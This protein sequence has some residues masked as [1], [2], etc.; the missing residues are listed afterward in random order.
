MTAMD[1]QT[2]D[3]ARAAALAGNGGQVSR[4][5]I[6]YTV[7]AENGE[8][9]LRQY[10]TRRISLPLDDFIRTEWTVV[11]TGEAAP[12]LTVAQYFAALPSGTH[13]RRAGSNDTYV[14]SGRTAGATG[15]PRRPVLVNMR[16]GSDTTL[17][18]TDRDN[19]WT[20]VLDESGAPVV[21]SDF[22]LR[23]LARLRNTQESYERTVEDNNKLRLDWS[24]LNEFINGYANETNMCSDYER[25]LDDWNEDFALLKLEGRKRTF[26]ISVRVDASYYV[27]VPVEATNEDA[28]HDAISDMS[29]YDV[30]EHA[31][32]NYPDSVDHEV[33]N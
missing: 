31:S 10:E 6:T 22:T 24:K 30:M 33:S 27:T 8:F 32:W 21:E 16:Y 4:S 9:R 13:V 15:E 28:A 23:M 25:R 19:D 26:E 18:L 29:S 5:D 1:T 2:Y 12:N 17:E 3:L 20:A 7:V 11:R 14:W